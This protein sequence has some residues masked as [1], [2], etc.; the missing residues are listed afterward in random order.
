MRSVLQYDPTHE[1]AKR[2]IEQA[3]RMLKGCRCA[4]KSRDAK[5][6]PSPAALSKMSIGLELARDNIAVAP[7]PN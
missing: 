4:N 2:N 3:E 1:G 5:V 6:P 7:Y